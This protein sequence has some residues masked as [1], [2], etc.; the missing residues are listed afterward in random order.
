[1]AD[2]RKQDRPK[3]S[4]ASNPPKLRDDWDRTRGSSNLSWVDA[5]A[6]TRDAW[7]RVRPGDNR[8]R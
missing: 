6:A 4:P 1:M 2:K 5:R 8:K 3:P 7:Q